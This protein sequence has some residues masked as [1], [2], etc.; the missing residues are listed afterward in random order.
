MNFIILYFILSKKI[1][2]NSIFFFI[3]S[4]DTLDLAR[5]PMKS[6]K[7]DYFFQ[8]INIDGNE[9]NQNKKKKTMMASPFNRVVL[10]NQ[11]YPLKNPA[12]S[13]GHHNILISRV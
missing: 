9:W 5:K 10:T 2:F 4:K 1:L 6:F 7:Q 3:L 11:R 8:R 12:F 13:K